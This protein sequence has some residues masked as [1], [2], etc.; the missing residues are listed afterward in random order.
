[1]YLDEDFH[2]LWELWESPTPQVTTLRS[3]PPQK[4]NSPHLSHITAIHRDSVEPRPPLL[5][6]DPVCLKAD[7]PRTAIEVHAR[8]PRNEHYT[9]TSQHTATPSYLS[10]VTLPLFTGR[11]STGSD[12]RMGLNWNLH[13]K[14]SAESL[15]NDTETMGRS[16]IWMGSTWETMQPPG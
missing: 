7:E 6:P 1:M 16:K 12:T 9:T 5:Q 14:Q 15:K 13:P 2:C 8:L 10:T 3:E 4:G 11:N